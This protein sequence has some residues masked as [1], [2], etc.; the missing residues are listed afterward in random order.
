[1][2]LDANSPADG[3]C[4]VDI[5]RD[6]DLHFSNLKARGG[7]GP[8]EIAVFSVDDAAVLDAG[9][10]SR[11][12]WKNAGGETRS[13][14]L[15]A[16]RLRIPVVVWIAHGTDGYGDPIAPQVGQEIAIADGLLNL[17]RI[18]LELDLEAVNDISGNSAED[19]QART[20]IGCETR[21]GLVTCLC[22]QSLLG[23]DHFKKRR[24]NVY[25]VER[26]W[27]AS[28]PARGL[29][30]SFTEDGDRMDRNVI[31]LSSISRY[32]ETLAHEIGHAL[33]L[34]HV[35]DGFGQWYPGKFPLDN[36]MSDHWDISTFSLGQA[37]RMNFSALSILFQDQVQS[38]KPRECECELWT[39]NCDRD[40]FRTE[41]DQAGVCP[42]ISQGWVP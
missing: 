30:C 25:Y 10:R 27:T 41:S 11:S 5:V 19:R 39:T 8:D 28:S 36:I 16:K 32:P 33:G 3:G 22:D 23:A 12:I 38:A 40:Q 42:A 14:D 17:N 24:L 35:R 15:A 7:C 4:Q 31:L 26:P 13:I 6:A 1:V 2:L 9:G 29:N 37:Y 34:Q 20:A 21:N 18:G